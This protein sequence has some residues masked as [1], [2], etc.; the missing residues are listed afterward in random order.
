M[1]DVSGKWPKNAS[2][3]TLLE[4]CEAYPFMY[5]KMDEQHKDREKLRRTWTAIAEAVSTPGK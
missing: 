4:Q 2:V 5:N 1:D 3:I